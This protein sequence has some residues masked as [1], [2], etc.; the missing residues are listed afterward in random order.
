MLREQS[1]QDGL[2]LLG[3]VTLGKCLPLSDLSLRFLGR[4]LSSII[5][6]ALIW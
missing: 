6:G 3:C 1:S 2:P 4:T 5:S